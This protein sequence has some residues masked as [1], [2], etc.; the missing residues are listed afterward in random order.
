M[1]AA[2][3]FSKIYSNETHLETFRFDSSPNLIGVTYKP[4][5]VY[6]LCGLSSYFFLENQ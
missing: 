5:H 6:D 3:L 1:A 2:E 4:V